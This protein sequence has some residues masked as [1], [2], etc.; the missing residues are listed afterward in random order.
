VTLADLSVLIL[1]RVFLR[2]VDNPPEVSK[3]RGVFGGVIS[4][5]FQVMFSVLGRRTREAPS[6]TTAGCRLSR[7]AYGLQGISSR[8]AFRLNR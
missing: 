4:S 7:A 1:A 8:K 2:V 6:L 3:R 5:V